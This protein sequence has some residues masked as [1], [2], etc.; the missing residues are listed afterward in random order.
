[1]DPYNFKMFQKSSGN[2]QKGFEDSRRFQKALE[3][4]VSVLR[5]N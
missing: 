2:F 3:E 5:R 1:M 4:K